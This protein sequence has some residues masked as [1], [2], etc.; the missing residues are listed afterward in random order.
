MNPKQTN[1]LDSLPKATGA[2]LLLHIF[3]WLATCVLEALVV[4]RGHAVGSLVA[5]SGSMPREMMTRH[6]SLSMCNLLLR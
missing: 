2:L 5:A 4:G 6:H 3:L 1:E